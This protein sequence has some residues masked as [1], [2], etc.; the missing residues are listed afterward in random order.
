MNATIEWRGGSRPIL[1]GLLY[2]YSRVMVQSTEPEFLLQH[3]FHQMIV[4]GFWNQFFFLL[5][6]KVATSAVT[7]P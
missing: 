1:F 5:I 7:V 6:A 3:V 2:Y 4:L